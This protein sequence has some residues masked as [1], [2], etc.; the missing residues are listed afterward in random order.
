MAIA[1]IK[2]GV[3]QDQRARFL[4]LTHHEKELKDAA[5]FTTPDDAYLLLMDRDGAIRWRF[6][7]A[8][9]DTARAE[10]KSQVAL[11]EPVESK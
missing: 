8:L 10:L 2:S 6:H 1:G 4:V 11:L 3:A 9:T 7:G 5:A